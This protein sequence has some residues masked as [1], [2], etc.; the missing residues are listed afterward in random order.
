MQGMKGILQGMLRDIRAVPVEGDYYDERN[1]LRCHECGS[2]KETLIDHWKLDGLYGVEPRYCVKPISC[3]CQIKKDSQEAEESAKRER[4]KELLRNRM[5]AFDVEG[6]DGCTF[7]KD[8]GQNAVQSGVCRSYVKNFSAARAKGQG[9]LMSGDVGTGKTFLAGC[10]ANAL[11]D[12]GY[13]VKCTSLAVLNGRAAANYQNIQPEIDALKNY[14]LVIFDDLGTERKTTT[15][16][17]NAFQV[18]DALEKAGVPM[19]FTTN[20]PTSEIAS[21][22]ERANARIYSRIIGKCRPLKFEGN[23]RRRAEDEWTF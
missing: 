11:L 2:P 14:D 18:I 3:E 9:I 1:I 10:I 8:D 16:N 6:M 20:I 5:R 4:E 22:G 7:D 17:E 13:R 19:V 12:E 15:A 21:D 23:D